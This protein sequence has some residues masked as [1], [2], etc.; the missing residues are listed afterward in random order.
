MGYCI[1]DAPVVTATDE[2][3]E[4]CVEWLPTEGPFAADGDW[5]DITAYVAQ[6]KTTGGRQHEIDRFQ[7]GSLSV[8]LRAD[9]RLFDTN[10]PSS[11]FAPY[12]L[13]MRQI[14]VSAVWDGVRYP[15]FR[16]YITDWGETVPDDVFFVTTL[17]ARDGFALLDQIQLLQSP[18]EYQLREVGPS[19]VSWWRCSTDDVNQP[20][21]D[22]MGLTHGQFDENP[23]LRQ[24]SLCA[25]D[26]ATSMKTTNVNSAMRVKNPPVSEGFSFLGYP[27]TL[28]ALFTM[29]DVDGILFGAGSSG[30]AMVLSGADY[31][32][33]GQLTG[34]MLAGA[35]LK[36]VDTTVL[37]NDG[38]VHHVAWVLPN[39]SDYALYI[40]GVDVSSIRNP[41]DPG[42]GVPITN[43]W[44]F[45]NAHTELQGSFGADYHWPGFVQ[46]L[47]AFDI[48]LSADEVAEQAV[49]ALDGWAGDTTGARVERM[50]D[51]VGWPTTL[52]D[53]DTGI[54]TMSKASFA[55]G[56]SL[57]AELGRIADTEVGLMFMDPEGRLAFWSRHRRYTEPSALTPVATFGDGHSGETFKYR[58]NGFTLERDEALLRN[59]VI[60]SREDGTTF[61]A[62]DVDMIE[63]YGRRDWTA[64]N[65]LDEFDSAIPSRAEWFLGRFKDNAPRL[66]M[67]VA[68]RAE[69]LMWPIVLSLTFDDRITVKRT[70][71]GSGT[72]I[73]SDFYIE[74]VEHSFSPT[75]WDA[76]FGGSPADDTEYFILDTSM[77]DTGRL[78]F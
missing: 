76:T 49:A 2:F 41:G 32:N 74:S 33:S 10:N 61:I 38:L 14:R 35:N 23:S 17:S 12:L 63:R 52:R 30:S 42:V 26:A 5:C 8:T 45:G 20:A 72:E 31:V 37:V 19:P 51:L 59:P 43:G 50:L 4:L 55:L 3:P 57:L 75:S 39:A 44:F 18:Y 54:S 60:A 62:S 67:T 58:N 73:A 7:T 71:L 25:S 48:A 34:Y 77:L 13:V 56:S 28:T 64:P 9:S 6:G 24:T 11:P 29:D 21:A 66:K 27:F 70:P 53:I 47:A 78:G 22:Q 36:I 16:G 15:R 46:D 40:D 65:S 69:P 68:P 1:D